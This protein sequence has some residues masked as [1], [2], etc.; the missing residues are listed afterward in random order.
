[1]GKWV[2]SQESVH[3]KSYPDKAKVVLDSGDG[4][5]K[6]AHGDRV[7]RLSRPRAGSPQVEGREASS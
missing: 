4:G 7:H 6:D 3:L 5:A 1:M 2:G